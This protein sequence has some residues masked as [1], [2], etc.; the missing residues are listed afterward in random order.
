MIHSVVIHAMMMSWYPRRR[1]SIP[2]EDI[3]TLGGPLVWFRWLKEP[4]NPLG[5]I[6]KPLEHQMDQMTHSVVICGLHGY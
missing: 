6:I 4:M 5:M 2:T 3:L 1:P